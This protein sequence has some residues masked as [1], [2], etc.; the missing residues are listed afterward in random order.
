MS[1]TKTPGGRWRVK[2]KSGRNNLA[3]K[4]FDR[5][6]DAEDWETAQR[7]ALDLGHYVDPRAGK[8]P[9]G[10]ALAAWMESRAG[11]VAS[12]TQKADRGRLKYLPAKLKNRPLSSVRVADLDELFS[13]LLRGGLSPASVSRVRALLG[14]FYSSA[15]RRGLVGSSPVPDSRVPKGDAISERQEVYPFTIH[16]LREVVAQLSERSPRQAELALVLGLT[17]LRWGELSG[18][19]VRDVMTVPHAALRV[20]RSASDGHAVRHRTKGGREYGRAVPL[21]REL[22]PIVESWASGKEAD[23]LLFTT[24]EGHRLNNSNWRRIVGWP[25]L[26]RGRRVHDLRHTAA[27]FWLSSGIDVKTVQTWLGHESAQLTLNLYSHWLGTTADA[28]ALARVN[29]A[30]SGNTESGGRRGD[31]A[32]NLRA[33]DAA[34]RP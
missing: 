7:R 28:A 13:D 15:R 6:K 2:L 31:A 29:D 17:G 24:G 5:K 20:L 26:C 3:S 11:T 23:D 25:A 34:A 8:E 9:L 32:P 30:L 21:A 18:M 12:T 4:T 22:I 19:R 1:V 33:A 16:E 14:A 10:V 27:T